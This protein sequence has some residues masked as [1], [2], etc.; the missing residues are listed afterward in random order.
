MKTAAGVCVADWKPGRRG[1]WGRGFTAGLTI[2]ALA[3]PA[4]ANRY[5][6][7][8][9]G[10]SHQGSAINDFGVIAGD[11]YDAHALVRIGGKWHAL[12]DDGGNTSFAEAIDDLGRIVGSETPSGEPSFPAFWPNYKKVVALPVPKKGWAGDATA[13]SNTGFIAGDYWDPQDFTRI[14][15]FLREP[16]GRTIDL[17]MLAGASKCETTGINDEGQVVGY[18]SSKSSNGSAFVW[19]AGR[20]RDL[21]SLGGPYSLAH[22]VN[23]RGQ[24]VGYSALHQNLVHAVLWEGGH[25]IDMGQSPDFVQSTAYAISQ[26]GH[27]VGS[28]DSLKT[29]RTEAVRFDKSTMVMLAEELDDPGDWWLEDATSINDR[30][31]ILGFGV[32]SDGP[33]FFLLKPID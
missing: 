1:L 11:E 2:C 32:R 25:V 9:L 17:G 21:G 13:V 16:G 31:E 29:G 15:C 30:G 27:I 3:S 19:Q 22:A 7:V 18:L 33:H 10:P 12:P 26:D 28:G 24:I 6:I 14:R 8:D 5:H 4:W 20:M 23:D